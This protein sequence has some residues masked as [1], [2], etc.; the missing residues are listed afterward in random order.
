MMYPRCA[1]LIIVH[2]L[3]ERIQA[4]CSHHFLLGFLPGKLMI[5]LKNN[6]NNKNCSSK[7][8]NNNNALNNKLASSCP[9]SKINIHTKLY[10]H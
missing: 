9:I 5:S 6:N 7:S 8:F 2:A 1:K 4:E 3:W 10:C